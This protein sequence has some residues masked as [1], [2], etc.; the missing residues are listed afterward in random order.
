MNEKKET[1]CDYGWTKMK[2]GCT[3]KAYSG[4]KHGKY[5]DIHWSKVKKYYKKDKE[6]S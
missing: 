2:N 1:T 4:N 5:C 3:R 6:E